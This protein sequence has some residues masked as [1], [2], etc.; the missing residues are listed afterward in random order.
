MAATKC[1]ISNNNINY[2][3]LALKYT[4]SYSMWSYE[5]LATSVIVCG[6]FEINNFANGKKKFKHIIERNS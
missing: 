5:Q 2:C 3:K 4:N 1:V 6:S